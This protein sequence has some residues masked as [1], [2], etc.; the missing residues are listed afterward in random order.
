MCVCVNAR[1]H[2]VGRF[3]EVCSFTGWVRCEAYLTLEYE[4]RVAADRGERGG[5][6]G[7]FALTSFFL[8]LCLRAWCMHVMGF[9]V[10]SGFRVWID[11]EKVGG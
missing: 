10:H 3:L 8:T 6:A 2:R 11:M 9:L 1:L 4:V 5:K 7:E